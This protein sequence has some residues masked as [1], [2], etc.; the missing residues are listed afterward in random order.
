M[1][2]ER[3]LNTVEQ[4]HADHLTAIDVN[5]A[6]FLI[7]AQIKR[8]KSQYNTSLTEEAET[9]LRKLS[10]QAAS[11]FE[12]A[13]RLE[14]YDRIG[15]NIR[16]MQSMSHDRQVFA[17][18]QFVVATEPKGLVPSVVT[19][20]N[21]SLWPAEEDSDSPQNDDESVIWIPQ[22]TTILVNN[23]VNLVAA[24][25]VPQFG[26]L[27]NL[28]T[29]LTS[30]LTWEHAL[31]L[32][33]PWEL[34]LEGPLAPA[35]PG[36]RS[37][38]FVPMIVPP[39]QA[40]LEERL[41]QLAILTFVAGHE[42]GHIYHGHTDLWPQTSIFRSVPDSVPRLCVDEVSADAAGIAAVWDGIKKN[43]EISIDIS[44]VGPILS[45]AHE[46]GITAAY[47]PEDTEK[48]EEYHRWLLRL[49]YALRAIATNLHGNDFEKLRSIQIVGAALPLAVAVYEYY[50]CG[51]DS[52]C[53]GPTL[54]ISG[55]EL[56]DTL[57]PL[58][59]ELLELFD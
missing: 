44:W 52:V 12:L 23:L 5:P 16:T 30:Y 47:P 13:D 31:D 48:E 25:L 42:A 22:N 49:E 46:A 54:G 37:L 43:H 7:E 4:R 6:D 51:G 38:L 53:D 40:E 56:Y 9:L 11:R 50:R 35:E 17:E 21:S 15:T 8:W 39:G 3:S 59:I 10:S 19:H 41:L 33:R 18:A 29:A 36:R 27:L 14:L 24:R 57:E 26:S 45:L 34:P 58:C 20:N 28:I 1:A 55:S 32:L 2:N